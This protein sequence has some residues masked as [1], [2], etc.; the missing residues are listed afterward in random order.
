MPEED[1]L[2]NG[3]LRNPST[4]RKKPN[5]NIEIGITEIKRYKSTIYLCE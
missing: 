1:Y 2:T 5:T 3:Q 4:I